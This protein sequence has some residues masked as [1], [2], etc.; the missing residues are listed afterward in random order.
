MYKES[1][2]DQNIDKHRPQR[3][4]CSAT[5]VKLKHKFTRIKKIQRSPYYRG[6][7]LWDQLPQSLQTE[8]TNLMFKIAIRKYVL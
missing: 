8:E 3:V 5:H 6:L 2:I 1:K 4:T 7:E